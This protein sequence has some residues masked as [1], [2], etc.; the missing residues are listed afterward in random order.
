MREKS[1][2]RPLSWI[3]YT[4]VLPIV[5][6]V[7]IVALIVQFILG[8]NVAGAASNWAQKIPVVRHVMGLGP[9]PVPVPIQI[10]NLD[11]VI[12][13]DVHELAVLREQNGGL[14]TQVASLQARIA[15][16]S[17]K[18][19]AAQRE[20]RTLT[21]SMHSAANAATVYID[22]APNE[23]ALIIARLPFDQQVL[24]LRAMDPADQ[25]SILSQF[26]TVQAAKLL[27]AGA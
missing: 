5:F 15:E 7:I 12:A 19:S 10:S 16:E 21:H 25:A 3:F 22:M 17:A 11:T 13:G 20:L 26:S 1:A 9:L 2:A 27:Q 24:T 14:Q 4:L 6:T 23:A 18:W 8:I